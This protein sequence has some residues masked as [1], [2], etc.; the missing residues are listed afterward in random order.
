MLSS[1]S[2]MEVWEEIRVFT[3][4]VPVFVVVVILCYSINV[5]SIVFCFLGS[6]RFEDGCL[7]GSIEDIY[8][9]LGLEMTI[10]WEKKSRLFFLILFLF[11]DWSGLIVLHSEHIDLRFF[12]TKTKIKSEF[13]SFDLKFGW[14]FGTIFLFWFPKVLVQNCL[15]VFEFVLNFPTFWIIPIGILVIELVK[16]TTNT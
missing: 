3:S 16:W 1:T 14:P 13:W 6:K 10:F 2:I 8:Q 4:W 15:E 11:F 5:V 7:E 12:P 9:I